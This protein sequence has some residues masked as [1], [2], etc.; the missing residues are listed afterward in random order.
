MATYKSIAYD[1]ILANASEKVLFQEQIASC[2]ATLS[3]TSGIDSTYKEYIFRFINIHPETDDTEWSFQGSTDSGSSYGVSI[4]ST[5][6]DAYH[7][8][9][10][11]SQNLEYQTAQDLANSTNFQIFQQDYG[12]DNDQAGC[13]FLH[14]FNPS[15]TTFVKHF[16]SPSTNYHKDNLC[17]NCNRSGYFNTTSAIDAI[18]F[19]FNSGDIDLG[20][21]KMYGVK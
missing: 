6:F 4:T 14:L 10:G 1:Q 20:T 13:G 7:D 19:K 15:S 3:F 2:D 16:I 5:S 12:N 11:G 18:Q 21:I 9:A 8:E 17:M